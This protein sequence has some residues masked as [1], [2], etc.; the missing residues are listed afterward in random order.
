MGAADQLKTFAKTESGET[1]K[2][3][4]EDAIKNSGKIA[5]DVMKKGGPLKFLFG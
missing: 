2:L 3:M 4:A 5:M 1:I